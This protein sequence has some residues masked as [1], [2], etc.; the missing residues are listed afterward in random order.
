MQSHKDRDSTS[1]YTVIFTHNPM[2]AGISQMVIT[3]KLE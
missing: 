3:D 2:I 1:R